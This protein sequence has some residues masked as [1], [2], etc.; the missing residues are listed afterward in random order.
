MPYE[1]LD[2]KQLK[3]LVYPDPVLRVK[4]KPVEAVTDQVRAAAQQMLELMHAAPGVGLAATQ[5]GLNLRFFVANATGEPG[6]DQVFIN[7]VLTD[8]SRESVEVEEGC[9]SLPEIRGVVRRPMKITIRAQDIEG[10]TF[11]ATS[12]EL[13]ARVWQHE[14]DHLDGI[15][16]IDRMAPLDRLAN[17]KRLREMERSGEGSTAAEDRAGTGAKA[18]AR[19]PV[20]KSR[21]RAD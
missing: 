2:V 9:L 8:P 7:P 13:A 12:D 10:R 21:R 1:R 15:L 6:D 16:I 18:R 11:E 17:Q 3:I 14:T 4:A 20:R 19:T 5:V